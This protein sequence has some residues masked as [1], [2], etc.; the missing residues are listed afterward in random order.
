[1]ALFH[2]FLTVSQKDF[3]SPSTST[4]KKKGKSKPV[5]EGRK[6]PSLTTN[7]ASSS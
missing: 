1:M 7:N 5:S 3:N 2:L 6:N 4:A